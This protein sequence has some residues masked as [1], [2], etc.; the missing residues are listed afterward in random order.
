MSGL[1]PL[2]L[3]RRAADPDMLLAVLDFLLSDDGMVLAFCAE[4]GLA[5]HA[6]MAALMALQGGAGMH[7]T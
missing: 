3:R 6:P 4:A 2:D 5:P 7:W 1:A